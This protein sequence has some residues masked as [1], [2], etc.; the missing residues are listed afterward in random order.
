[1][2]EVAIRPFTSPDLTQLSTVIIG[3]V[4]QEKY[5]VEKRESEAETAVILKL[6]TLPAPKTYRY[7]HLDQ[8]E[9]DRLAGIVV[10]GFSFSAFV[11]A[12]LVGVALASPEQWNRSLRVWEFH[13]ADGLR[14]QG[15]GRRLMDKVVETAVSHQLR[16]IVCETQSRNVP[17]IRA[18]RRL[19]FVLDA[20]DLS[21][22]SNEDVAKEDVAVFMKRKL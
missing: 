10:E 18:Y 1:M 8:A 7:D 5:V 6:V 3:Y 17:A 9:M 13:V 15:I 2:A 16:V 20:V 12:Q 19:G 4:T 14:G 22:Y 11:G 21:F